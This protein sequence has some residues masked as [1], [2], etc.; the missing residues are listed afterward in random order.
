MDL[1][2]NADIST[3]Y[4]QSENEY[5]IVTAI[6]ELTDI[7]GRESNCW[8][9]LTLEAR[10]RRYVD[11]LDRRIILKR[12][13]LAHLENLMDATIKY[14]SPLDLPYNEKE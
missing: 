2:L 11:E 4:L 9:K 12:K 1:A 10:K 14:R 7:I 5:N 8:R 3:R 6:A 13:E